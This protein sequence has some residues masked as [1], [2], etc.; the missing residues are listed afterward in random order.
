MLLDA[1]LQ[2]KESEESALATRA[3]HTSTFQ[4]DYF[5]RPAEIG[6]I[7]NFRVMPEDHLNYAL[8]WFVLATSVGFLAVRR[9]RNPPQRYAAR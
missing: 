6:D 8:T 9:L 5:P 3:P 7:T 2:T 4:R 1:I